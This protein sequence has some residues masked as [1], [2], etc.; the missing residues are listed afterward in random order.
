MVLFFNNGYLALT[1]QTKRITMRTCL[2][3][4]VGLQSEN[5]LLFRPHF[6]LLFYKDDSAS[7]QHFIPASIW[8]I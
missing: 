6:I 5:L 1:G 2:I 4:A 8:N 7:H 3:E